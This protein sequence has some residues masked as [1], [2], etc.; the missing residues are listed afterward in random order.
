[1]WEIL[2]FDHSQRMK[3]N[4]SPLVLTTFHRLWYVT[5]QRITPTLSLYFRMQFLYFFNSVHKKYL[6]KLIWAHFNLY[7]N[8]KSYFSL[9]MFIMMCKTLNCPYIYI[10]PI[11]LHSGYLF[12]L[13]TWHLSLLGPPSFTAIHI[14]IIKN[15]IFLHVSTPGCV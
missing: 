11:I 3:T 7:I 8:F 6:K 1:M 9:T 4:T 13:S 14:A 10:W 2:E 15:D 12:R 5:L